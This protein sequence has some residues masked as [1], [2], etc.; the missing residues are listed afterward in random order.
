MNLKLK[1]KT[2]VIT[3]IIPR[4]IAVTYVYNFFPFKTYSI[5]RDYLCYL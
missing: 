1:L 3:V 2:M 4:M 5:T